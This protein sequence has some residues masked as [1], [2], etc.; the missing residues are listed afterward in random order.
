MVIEGNKDGTIRR[1]EPI[2][3]F[4][5]NIFYAIRTPVILMFGKNL[6]D[7]LLLGKISCNLFR[8]QTP[9]NNGGNL[10][11]HLLLRIA[12][13]LNQNFNQTC[14]LTI[15]TAMEKEEEEEA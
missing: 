2:P 9:Q 10:C 5:F 4:W 8:N 15:I 14:I 13:H 12:A 1:Y 7:I 11:V 3:P 6:G